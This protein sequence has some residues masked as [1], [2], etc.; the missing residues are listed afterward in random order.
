MNNIISNRPI[1]VGI[2]GAKRGLSFASSAEFTGMELAAVCDNFPPYLKQAEEKFQVPAYENFDD[3]IKHDMD[4]VVIA[5]PFHRHAP[6]A[7]RALKAGRHVLSETS[8]NI[9]LAEG[10]ELCRTVEETGLCY[11]LAENYC[12]YKSSM[13][14]RKRYAEGQI[15]EIRYA[16][17]EYNHPMD[18]VSGLR[19]APGKNHWR[20]KIPPTYY[21]THALAPLMYITDTLPVSVQALSI[22]CDRKGTF[23]LGDS[24]FISLCR[25]DNGAV[26]KLFGL[27]LPGHSVYYRLHGTR[28]AMETTRG[29]G[30]F[31]TGKVRVWLDEWLKKPEEETD[32][33][34]EPQW[35]EHGELA[36]KAGHGGGDFFT[37]YYFAEAI[38]TGI[39][40]Y[41]DVY[42]GVSMSNVGI[43]SWKSALQNGAPQLLP[44]FRDEN[45]RKQ[46]ENDTDC[47]FSDVEGATLIPYHTGN[48]R[49]ISQDDSCV[50]N[51]KKAWAE[52]SYSP[53]DI[54]KML[55]ESTSR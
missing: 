18:P 22:K 32:A 27:S 47:P 38:R 44:D 52:A 39:S 31:G 12:Y 14:M 1:R 5:T 8:C 54:E 2:V 30:Y 21:N 55:N 42:K 9:T 51:A 45:V 26:F 6:F 23:S 29:P 3:F 25:M 10:V 43:L 4:A 46:Y 33:E 48:K 28:G 36:E 35:G 50:E 11:M 19:I 34:F 17:G 24:G 37:E 20:A 7:I 49:D 15:G 13:D 40:P 53:Q 41:L 16:E